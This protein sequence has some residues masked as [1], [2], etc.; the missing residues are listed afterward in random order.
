MN[1]LVTQL[2]YAASVTPIMSMGQLIAQS[3][4]DRAANEIE[5][6]QTLTGRTLFL[7][8]HMRYGQE[9]S[10]QAWGQWLDETEEI[11]KEAGR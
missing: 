9:A 11:L 10:E 2:R 1:E 4:C 7:L 6:L 5:R 3:L 8:E